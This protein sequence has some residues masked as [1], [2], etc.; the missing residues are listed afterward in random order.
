MVA[1]NA[2]A[3][4]LFGPLTESGSYGR[5]I[6]HRAFSSPVLSDSLDEDGTEQLLRVAAA[7]LRAALSR[8]P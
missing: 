2:S 3:L 1:A 8:Y 7:E 5:N 6:V 4:D